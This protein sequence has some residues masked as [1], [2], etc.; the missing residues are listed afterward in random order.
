MQTTPTTRTEPLAD[1]P[2]SSPEFRVRPWFPR[3]VLFF[4]VLGLAVLAVSVIGTGWMLRSHAGDAR[5]EGPPPEISKVIGFGFVDVE[6]GVVPLRAEQPGSV[7]RMPVKENQFVEKGTLLLELDSKLARAKADEARADL[8]VAEAKQRAAEDLPGSLDEEIAAQEDVIVAAEKEVEAARD[9]AAKAARMVKIG[10]PGATREDHQAALKLVA[11]A[12]AMVRVQKAKLRGLKLRKKQTKALIDQAKHQVAAKKAQ[13]QQATDVLGQFV[14]K[15]PAD[16]TVLR[17]SVSVGE[18]IGPTRPEPAMIFCPGRPEDRIIRAEIEQE[19]AAKVKPGMH[20]VVQDDA[21]LT[22]KWEGEVKS[23][24]DW[25]AHR[26][27]LLLEP[28]QFNDVRTLECIIKLKPGQPPLKI[29]QR[30]RVT[31]GK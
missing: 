21:R 12:E 24:S 19:F 29:G 13:L 7:L 17:I 5:D 1:R 4:V 11:S 16:G 8:E 27:S 18:L 23:V 28:R 26:R 6:G 30:M 10:A 25:Y 15:A 3:R 31:L 22:G 20:A 14:I 2:P 9:R